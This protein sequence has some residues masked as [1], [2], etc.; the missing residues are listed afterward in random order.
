MALARAPFF[1]SGEQPRSNLA[2]G[3]RRRYPDG[4]TSVLAAA[5]QVLAHEFDLLGSGPRRVG[6]SLPWHEDFKTGAI[7]PRAYAFDLDYERLTPS[8]DVKVPWEL[9][10]FQHAASLGQAW[11]LSRREAYRDEFVAQVDDWIRGNPWGYSV[12]WVCAM[13]VA[14]RAHNLQWGYHYLFGPDALAPPGFALR[15]ARLLYLHGEFIEANLERSEVNGNH[16]LADAVGLISIGS[17]FRHSAAGKRWLDLGSRIVSEEIFRQVHPD[18]V[19][20][21]QSTAYHRLVTEMFLTGFLLLRTAGHEP[22]AAAWTRLEKMFDYIAAYTR[23]DGQAPVIGDADDGRM[24]KL[25]A[26]GINDHRYLLA[27]GARLFDRPDLAAAAGRY[28]EEAYWMLGADEAEAFDRMP[29][30]PPPRPTAFPDGGIYILRAGDAH[31]IVDC[32]EVGMNGRGGHGHN[33]IL[34]FELSLSGRAV[35]VDCGAYVYTADPEARDRFRSTAFHNGVQIDGEEVNRFRSPRDLWRL[36][37]DARP[38]GVRWTVEG[39]GGAI[40]AAHTG[41]LRLADPVRHRRTCHL[42]A[43]GQLFVVEDQLVGDAEHQGTWRFHLSPSLNAS[44]NGSTVTLTAERESWFVLLV[45]PPAI[46]LSLNE[47]WVSPSYGVKERTTV[48]RGD[49]RFRGDLRARWVFGV[50]SPSE[51]VVRRALDLVAAEQ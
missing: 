29:A 22:A 43:D 10:R 2:A 25:A 32:A 24:H 28:W 35:I 5:D 7:W 1:P 41:Y 46:T 47:G 51:P 40:A 16:Y 19:D 23:P 33:D 36:H 38:E 39:D 37:D 9:S 18:G 34:S 15:F 13:D 12:N 11:L 17:W 48:I 44:L 27:I 21:E 49:A 30:A 20:F 3:F 4:V 45:D 50:G 6:A 8:S 26:R 14:I 42:S 31:A